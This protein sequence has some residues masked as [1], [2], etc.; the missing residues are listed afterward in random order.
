MDPTINRD[1]VE[2]FSAKPRAQENPVIRTTMLL[3]TAVCVGAASLGCSQGA[4]DPIAGNAAGSPTTAAGSSSMAGA[5]GATSTGGMPAAGGN[6][7]AGGGTV[8]GGT[9]GASAGGESTA[10]TSTMAG[11][12]GT[13]AG[14]SGGGGG[15]G[16]VTPQTI[17]PTV[18]GLLWVGECADAVGNGKDCPIQSSMGTACASSTDW[19][20]SGAFK[21]QKHT[22]GGTPGTKYLLDVDVRGVT[23]GKNYNGGMRQSTATAF[24][25]TE[26]DG[27]YVGG[28]PTATKWNTYEIHVT[29]PVPGQPV[30]EQALTCSGCP[31]PPDNVYYTNSIAGNADGTHET[32]P[33]KF[34]AKFPVL[35]G[36]T[37]TL[38]IHDSNCLGQQ[39]CGPN[40]D[41]AAMCTDPR[42]VD[43]SGMMPQPPGTFT[44]P[45]TQP[46]NPNPWYPQWLFLDVKSVTQQ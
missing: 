9:G 31:T 29:P 21:V 28:L 6:A 20:T 24:S 15:G 26:N 17:V 11:A 35:G 1:V 32:F 40:P 5:S 25:Q 30:N 43:L 44:Q 23:G 12:A 19:F 14:G 46:H 4:V 36:G 3:M 2:G 38:I 33:I 45:F 34:N 27:W 7:G 37:I 16:G 39:N 41:A 18:D 22:V 13:N 42:S 8:A 10:G